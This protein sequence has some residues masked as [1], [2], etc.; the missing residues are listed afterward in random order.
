MSVSHTDVPGSAAAL[1]GGSW[2]FLFLFF[3][4]KSSNKA[5][6]TEQAEVVQIKTIREW[7]AVREGP[8]SAIC[9]DGPWR[10]G[11]PILSALVAAGLL[12]FPVTMVSRFLLFKGNEQMKPPQ[13]A[14]LCVTF[15]CFICIK[16]SCTVAN[17]WIISEFKQS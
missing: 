7:A 5:F 12:C 13:N 8:S 14:L 4:Q 16:A 9:P 1:N 10:G 6:L 17:I 2:V 11:E 3:G 15:S